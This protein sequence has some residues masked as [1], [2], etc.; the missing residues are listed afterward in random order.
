MNMYLHEVKAMR[1]SAIIWTCAL[2]A[3]A[4]LYLMIFPSMANNVADY[5]KLLEGYPPQIREILNINLNYISSVVGFYSMV[6]SFIILSGAIQAMNIG[7]SLLSKENRERTADF[8]LVK[9]VSRSKIV[10]EKILAA[11]TILVLTNI[12]FNAVTIIIANS[13]KTSSFDV[14]LFF[15][16]NLSM[17]FVQL[18]FLALGLCISVFFKKLKSVL[19]ISLGVVFGFYMIGALVVAG[20]NSDVARYISPF[21]YFNLNY[22]IKNGSYEVSYLIASVIIILIALVASYIIYIKKDIHSVS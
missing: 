13:V 22:I 16:I 2:I 10:T 3:L 20:S 6:F 12:V 14:K 17:F 8:L 18:I 1:K 4:T 9:P 21:E 5:K 19:P 15:M 7:V 11:L